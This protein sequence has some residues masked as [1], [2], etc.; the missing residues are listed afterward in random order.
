MNKAY[1]NQTVVGHR[2]YQCK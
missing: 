2:A 1:K